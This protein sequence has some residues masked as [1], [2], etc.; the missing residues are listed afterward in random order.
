MK[1][2]HRGDIVLFVS[3]PPYLQTLGYLANRFFNLPYACL[4]YDLYP[5]VAVELGVV[6]E[7]HWLVRF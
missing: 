1:R 5:D 2:E 7:N 4:V 3:E 6:S